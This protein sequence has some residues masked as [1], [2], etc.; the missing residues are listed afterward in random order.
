MSA[1]PD[2]NRLARPYRWME[3]AS[4]VPVLWWCRCT[5]LDKF[6]GCRRA[7][8]LGDGDGRFT[9]RLLQTNQA[10][11]I[12]A[13]D[14]STAMLSAL[15]R[16]AGPST[17]RVRTFEADARCWRPADAESAPD[18]DD[19]PRQPYDLIVTHFFLDCLTTAEVE[20]LARA[21]RSAT[22]PSARW[23]ISEFAVPPG[24][25]GRLIAAPLI[26]ALYLAFGML[27]GL[28]VRTLP[29]YASSL[30]HAGF[31]LQQ[32]RAWLRGLLVS[33]IWHVGPCQSSIAGPLPR[34]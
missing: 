2:F 34:P 26:A 28:K 33:E 5:F 31:S 11:R 13:V 9:A 4:F 21:L 10:I 8:V 23:V 3:F 17:C 20:S 14:A 1:P 22:A 7:L 29:D 32:R 24:W 19:F 25:F 30:R 15:I 27:T 16:S 6:R 12:D 18:A